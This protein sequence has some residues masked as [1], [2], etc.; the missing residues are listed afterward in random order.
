[1][2]H[3]QVTGS[4]EPVVQRC[5]FTVPWPGLQRLSWRSTAVPPSCS[6]SLVSASLYCLKSRCRDS[7]VQ[8]VFLQAC[9]H[10]T[11]LLFPDGPPVASSALC[12]LLFYLLVTERRI[13]R[14]FLL[15]G[16][17]PVLL[18]PQLPFCS[19]GVVWGLI[20]GISW[21]LESLDSCS[22]MQTAFP[23]SWLP[24]ITDVGKCLS[25]QQKWFQQCSVLTGA[26]MCF[27]IN[28][29]RMK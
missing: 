3:Q 12:G 6:V 24:I 11:L 1:M 27:G 5:S 15:F 28:K 4:S 23:L 22:Q 14:K 7:G 8:N 25:Y 13:G 20:L 26:E 17:T 9:F 2:Q 21:A 29:W 18:P 19:S 10:E 16:F